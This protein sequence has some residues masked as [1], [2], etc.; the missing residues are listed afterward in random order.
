V[1]VLLTGASGS[2]GRQLRPLLVQDYEAVL[3]NS[4]SAITDLHP[5]ETWIQGDICDPA[6]MERLMSQVDGVIHMAGL[7]GPDYTFEQTLEPNFVATYHLFEAAHRHHVQRIIYASTHHAIGYLERGTPVDHLTPPRPDSWY[8]VTKAAGELIASY[9]ADRYG[10]DVMSI[11]I[12]YV[13]KNVPDER[14]VHT[15][16]SARDLAALIKLGL[17]GPQRG[18]HLVYGI[19]NCPEP[20]FDNRYAES[21]GYHPQDSSLENLADP[22]IANAQ[23]D[24]NNPLQ[25]Y[26]GG[27]FAV[28]GNQ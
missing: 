15:W 1:R 7:V 4:R 21:L 3:L 13:E 16:N 10:L 14:R 8:G 23:R 6:L 5:K 25:R 12:G 19:S 9:A 26:I 17:T 22:Q 18:Y 20:M 27:H 28:R 11:R 2:V 24:P